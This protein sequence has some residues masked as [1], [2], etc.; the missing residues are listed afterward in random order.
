MKDDHNVNKI[1]ISTFL[2]GRPLGGTQ[3]FIFFICFITLMFDGFDT[4]V[5]GFLNTP[6]IDD[7]ASRTGPWPR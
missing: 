5:M 7:W 6:L 2:D 3:W 1:D 4:A